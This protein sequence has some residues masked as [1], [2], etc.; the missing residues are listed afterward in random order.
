MAA[1]L[2]QCLNTHSVPSWYAKILLN[3]FLFSFYFLV[4]GV[5]TITITIAVVMML[6]LQFS[7]HLLFG[8]QAVTLLHWK[9]LNCWQMT[10]GSITDTP[11]LQS[12]RKHLNKKAKTSCKL[13]MKSPKSEDV[14]FALAKIKNSTKIK[15]YSAIHQ[16]QNI[17]ICA[18]RFLESSYLLVLASFSLV[19]PNAHAHTSHFPR[20]AHL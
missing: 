20:T 18:K 5:D 11:S 9:N 15:K 6:F 2:F 19:A 17:M 10:S 13:L 7:Y 4:I 8:I 16:C 3:Y 12:R 1:S 14:E